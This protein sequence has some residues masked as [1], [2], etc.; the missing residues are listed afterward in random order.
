MAASNGVG[1]FTMPAAIAA[2]RADLYSPF[3]KASA[4]SGASRFKRRTR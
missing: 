2:D 4:M 1:T 3:A